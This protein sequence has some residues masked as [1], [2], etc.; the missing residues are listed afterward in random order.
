MDRLDVA[1]LS[2]WRNDLQ[3][4][5]APLEDLRQIVQG[6]EH[7]THPLGSPATPMEHVASRVLKRSLSNAAFDLSFLIDVL[8]RREN[9]GADHE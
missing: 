5:R 4:M 3:D 8:N 7:L 2:S 6:V 9:Q 1:M